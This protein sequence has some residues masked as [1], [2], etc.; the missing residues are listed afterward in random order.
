MELLTKSG[1]SVEL[2]VSKSSLIGTRL[3]LNIDQSANIKNGEGEAAIALTSDECKEL[4][5]GL[6]EFIRL[7]EGQ[8][9]VL[10]AKSVVDLI[11]QPEVQ[12][13]MKK[14]EDEGKIKKLE[15]KEVPL[16][17]RLMR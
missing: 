13:V 4:I 11:A 9:Y 7:L 3:I 15:I 10:T 14:L 16:S 6:N 12:E 1:G 17:A 8:D 5:A 2:V